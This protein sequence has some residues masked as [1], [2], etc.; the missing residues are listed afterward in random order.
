MHVSGHLARVSLGERSELTEEDK[1]FD[2]ALKLLAQG[3]LTELPAALLTSA[4]TA[5]AAWAIGKRRKQGD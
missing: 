3:L 2:I 4:I 5:L 1:M